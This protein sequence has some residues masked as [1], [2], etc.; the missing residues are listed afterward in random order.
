MKM[1]FKK[2]DT[3]EIIIY[4]KT[5]ALLAMVLSGTIL[6]GVSSC[7][8][9]EV[10]QCQ[11]DETLSETFFS[12]ETVTESSPVPTSPPTP[13][14]TPTPEPK[15]ETLPAAGIGLQTEK[16]LIFPEQGEPKDTPIQFAD[17]LLKNILRMS[18]ID[19]SRETYTRFAFVRYEY[20]HS[21][22]IKVFLMSEERVLCVDYKT[23]CEPG[24]DTRIY[25]ENIEDFDTTSVIWYDLTLENI[26]EVFSCEPLDEVLSNA[27]FE[28]YQSLGSMF[29]EL[30][31]RCRYNKY[32]HTPLEEYDILYRVDDE[33]SYNYF[34]KIFHTVIDMYPASVLAY[35]YKDALGYCMKDLNG[36]GVDEL[37]LL[38][39]NLNGKGISSLHYNIIGIFTMQDGKPLLLDHGAVWIDENGRIYKN[40]Y[41]N[42]EVYK[43][44]ADGTSLEL[45][46]HFGKEEND[47]NIVYFKMNGDTKELISQDEYFL[48]KD[49][50]ALPENA[51]RYM[52]QVLTITFH[53][54]YNI[55][56]PSEGGK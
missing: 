34:Q 21:P 55:P 45:V 24:F 26:E 41:D 39:E 51:D 17:A 6:L 4:V 18:A 15:P 29:L 43:I 19:S 9:K 44:S 1:Q 30:S 31:H 2:Y 36:D 16:Y 35:D 22:K 53:P 33:R 49:E 7:R 28:S 10:S 52:K 11:D 56:I 5:K 27:T 32:E 38:I 12:Q 20:A 42:P 8:L 3:K 37:L 40:V 23:E 13:I 54:F 48:L 25:V 14:P 47:G 46:E 50:Y